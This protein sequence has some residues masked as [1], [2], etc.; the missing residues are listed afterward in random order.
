MPRAFN[1]PLLEVLRSLGVMFYTPPEGTVNMAG[2]VFDELG[3]PTQIQNP[4]G[5]LK[6]FPGGGGGGGIP[7]PANNSGTDVQIET[8]LGG[9]V[10]IRCIPDVVG[11]SGGSVQL[12][13]S[14]TTADEFPGGNII[15]AA[16]N[17]TGVDADGGEIQMTAGLAVDAATGGASVTL[18]GGIGADGEGGS[19]ELRVGHGASLT[20]ALVL[21]AT[22][23]NLAVAADTSAVTVAALGPVA[24]DVSITKW[25]PVTLDGVDGFLPFF[26]VNP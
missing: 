17:T 7:I 19:L 5:V 14:D 26:T 3:E 1:N 24:G 21:G 6:D 18:R 12:I 25:C 20:G 16:G 8:G 10:E 13:A 23:G 15:I 11:E 22:S 4:D 2:I 9:G